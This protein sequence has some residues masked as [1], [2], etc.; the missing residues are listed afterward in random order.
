VPGWWCILPAYCSQLNPVEGIWCQLKTRLAANRLYGSM[1]LLLD[2]VG[3]LFHQMT[4]DQALQ[5]AGQNA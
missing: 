4:P 3:V 5:W 2:T 1:A